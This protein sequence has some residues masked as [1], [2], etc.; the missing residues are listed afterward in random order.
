MSSSRII[1]SLLVRR[2]RDR[3]GMGQPD[4]RVAA[5]S[6]IALRDVGPVDVLPQS[7]K[8]TGSALVC[9]LSQHDLVPF[10]ESSTD[11]FVGNHFRVL[12][13]FLDGRCSA[14]LRP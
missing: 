7:E 9:T 14:L 5:D 8:N 6:S 4:N 2:P 11:R 1:I 13:H 12:L 3:G 10:A